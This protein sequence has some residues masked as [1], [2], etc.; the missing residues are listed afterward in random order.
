MRKKQLPKR[1]EILRKAF[2]NKWSLETVNKELED[3]LCERL[4]ARNIYEAG[5]GQPSY[6]KQFVRDWLKQN[7]DSDYDLPEEVIDKT[8]AKYKEAYEQLTGEPFEA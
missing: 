7:P 1:I 2:E 3:N 5:K 8:V 4:Y 6:D